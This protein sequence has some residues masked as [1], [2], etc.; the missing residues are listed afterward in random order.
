MT[1][2][3][4]SILV[5]HGPNLALLG[6]R[7][8]EIYGTTTL[9]Q[10]DASLIA[11]GGELGARVTCERSNHEGKRAATTGSSSTPAV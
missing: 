6:R 10:V 4:L 8:P 3:T 9:D 5:L 2:P 7:E 11:L 1:E